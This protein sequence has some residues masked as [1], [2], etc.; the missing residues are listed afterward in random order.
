MAAEEEGVTPDQ[1]VQAVARA[2]DRSASES[3]SGCTPDVSDV[4]T[5]VALA[6]ATVQKAIKGREKRLVSTLGKAWEIN[7]NPKYTL[8]CVLCGDTK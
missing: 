1:G 5:K 2:D 4:Q 7:D 8:Q 6:A 3:A